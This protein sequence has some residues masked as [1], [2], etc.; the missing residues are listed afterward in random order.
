MKFLY[1]IIF[2][3]GLG[4]GSFASVIIHRLHNKEGGIFWGRSKCPN[5]QHLLNAVDLIPLFGCLINRLKCRYC[6]KPISLAYPILELTMG[7]FFLL[8]AVFT[9]IFN[10]FLLIYYLLITFIFV[11][12]SFYDIFYQE[13]PDEISLPAIVLAGIAGF[14]GNLNSPASM[15]IGLAIPVLF[16][17][18]LF[19]SSRGRWLGGGDIRIGAIMGLL[20]GWPNILIGLF[21]GYLSGSIYSLIGLISGKLTRRSQIPFGPFLFLGTYMALFFGKDILN[22]YLGMI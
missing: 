5:C 13:I 14:I 10:T 20:L 3:I 12:L 17:A 19:I 16:F 6:K 22:W 21:L 11:V 2:L 9:G 4:F 1:L 8:T 15:L 18:T 7:S